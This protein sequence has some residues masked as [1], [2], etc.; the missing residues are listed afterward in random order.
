MSIV[1]YDITWRPGMNIDTV[2]QSIVEAAY[3]Y[4]G[5]NKS[6]AARSLGIS[7][8][9]LDSRLERIEKAKLE[10]EEKVD[11]SFKR[12]KEQAEIQRGQAI[13]TRYVPDGKGGVRAEP[14][15]EL[16]PQRSMPM[17]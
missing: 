3:K 4:F 14:V 11:A 10:H 2:V 8:R 16:P 13:G 15:A 7:V 6:A 1:R 12:R 5:G 9:T 17:P